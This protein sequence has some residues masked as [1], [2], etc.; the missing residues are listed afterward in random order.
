MPDINT[1]QDFESADPEHSHHDHHADDFESLSFTINEPL[2]GKKLLQ[3]LKSLPKAILRAK[4]ILNLSDEPHHR[5]IYQS[6]GSRWS[7]TK[8][9][10]WGNEKQHSGLVFIGPAGLLDH[11]ELKTRLNECLATGD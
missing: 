9:E 2:D 6:V 3:F 4:G 11:S 1:K 5:T 10:P 8:A 7:F